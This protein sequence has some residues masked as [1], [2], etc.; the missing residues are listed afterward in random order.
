MAVVERAAAHAALDDARD[1]GDVGDA[2]PDER[3]PAP[4]PGTV[5]VVVG[6]VRL[7]PRVDAERRAGDQETADDERRRDRKDQADRDHHGDDQQRVDH[8]PQEAAPPVAERAGEPVLDRVGPRLGQQ[9]VEEGLRLRSVLR[10]I[11]LRS[12]PPVPASGATSP[13]PPRQTAPVRPAAGSD[14]CARMSGA[15]GLGKRRLLGVDRELIRAF[16]RL[17]QIGQDDLL[18]QLADGSLASARLA[19]EVI[20]GGP[21]RASYGASDLLRHNI[22]NHL[23]AKTNIPAQ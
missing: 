4:E 13:P 12:V 6:L 15:R 7:E 14:R 19:S 9:P 2:E 3:E 8:A 10:L 1:A 23:M 21:R 18:A 17:A 16:G 11:G 5:A 20:I 22:R